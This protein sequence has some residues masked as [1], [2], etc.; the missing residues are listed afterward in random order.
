M[1]YRRRARPVRFPRPCT[2]EKLRR[3]RVVVVA[4]GVG[5]LPH[6]AVADNRTTAER[7]AREALE[8]GM[9]AVAV[10][11]RG[12]RGEAA[13]LRTG[14][15]VDPPCRSGRFTCVRVSPRL[16]TPMRRAEAA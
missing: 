15:R 7:F 6:Y 10:V 11:W 3:F 2:R 13:L 8:A 5:F 14:P 1:K 12:R 4:P 9:L 16:L